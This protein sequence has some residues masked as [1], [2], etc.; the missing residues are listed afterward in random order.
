MTIHTIGEDVKN[1][2]I[3]YCI[4]EYVRPFKYRELLRDHWFQQ[5]TIGELAAEYDMSET[6]V[7]KVL[8]GIGDKILI[9]ASNM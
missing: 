1:S 8:Y 3:D 9:K 2:D 6:A 4:Q 5:K 7:K